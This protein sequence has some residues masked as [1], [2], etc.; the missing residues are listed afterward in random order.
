VSQEARRSA[1]TVSVFFTIG[2]PPLPRRRGPRLRSERNPL[3]HFAFEFD[4]TFVAKD[5]VTEGRVVAQDGG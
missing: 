2:P 1:I 4:G 3:I 5:W